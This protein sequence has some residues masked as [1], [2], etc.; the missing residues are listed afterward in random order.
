M[1]LL[2]KTYYNK[3]IR[4]ALPVIFSFAGQAL[5]Q[6]ADSVMTGQL[7]ATPLAAVSLSG[8]VV[9]N[10]LVLG[11]GLSVGLTPIAGNFWAT[12]DFR[13]VSAYFQNSLLVNFLASIIITIALLSILPFLGNIGQPQEVVGIMGSYYIFITASIIPFM[14]FQA[15]KQF[16]EGAGNTRIAMNITLIANA[17]NILLNYLLIFGKF[18]FP[19]MG[20]AGA[21][22]ATLV[23]RIFMPIAFW[24]S[25]KKNFSFSR[26]FKF[27]SNINFSRFKQKELIKMGLPISGQMSIEFL[28]LS[29]ITIMMGWISTESLAANQIV[30]TMI[31][32]T[33]MVSNGISAATTIHVS[34]SFGKKDIYGIKKNGYAGIHLSALIMTIAA[35]IFLFLGEEIASIFTNSQEVIEISGKIFIVVAFFEILD[36]L[37]V[38]ALGALRGIMDVRAAMKYA[39]VS[40]LFVSIPFAYFAGFVLGFAEV[41]L[42]SGFAVGLLVASILFITRFNSKTSNSHTLFLNLGYEK[43]KL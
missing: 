31:N 41:G 36:G 35:I 43:E 30:L 6:I 20:I 27:F 4:V 19:Q 26:Y 12:G 2:P 18:G 7:G 5:V 22:L 13:R 34:H 17:I 40:Y 16:M 33:F 29:L 15:F 39:I 28:S 38:T 32:L 21:G 23:S 8:A 1:S 24:L 10:F 9:M 42:M 11:I 14:L 37:Q 25:I 3:N